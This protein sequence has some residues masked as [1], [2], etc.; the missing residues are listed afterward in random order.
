[1]MKSATIDAAVPAQAHGTL[2]ENLQN[3][4]L[5]PKPS[6]ASTWSDL[7]SSIQGLIRRACMD[8]LPNATMDEEVF[9]DFLRW[10][11]DK[12]RLRA[13]RALERK[14]NFPSGPF[15]N[16]C[17][18]SRLSYGRTPYRRPH[19]LS[20]VFVQDCFTQS[21]PPGKGDR[22]QTDVVL[23]CSG[24][25]GILAV[26]IDLEFA[27]SVPLPYDLASIRDQQFLLDWSARRLS[28][29]DEAIKKYHVL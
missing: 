26:F 27:Y 18:V 6:V 17:R 11:E 23:I 22:A 7:S 3:E 4:L 1:M 15:E 16:W 5:A 19:N 10:A 24:P 9:A 8:V 2:F 21:A 25:W 29:R 28:S 20:E 12:P 13:A 14:T